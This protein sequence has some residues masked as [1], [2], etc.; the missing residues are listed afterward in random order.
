MHMKKEE[1]KNGAKKN[2]A[3]HPYAA[4][5]AEMEELRHSIEK[6]HSPGHHLMAGVIRGIGTILGATIIFTAVIYISILVLKSLGL[7]QFFDPA[8]FDQLKSISN[9]S[10]SL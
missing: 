9:L 7:D 4:L 5:I 1:T 2:R 6:A 8:I 3:K 10:D